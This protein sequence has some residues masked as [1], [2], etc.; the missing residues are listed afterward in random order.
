MRDLRA[1]CAIRL[2]MAASS[3]VLLSVGVSCELRT[4]YHFLKLFEFL[5]STD[6]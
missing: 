2:M 1:I 4:L 5:I 3:R 6:I